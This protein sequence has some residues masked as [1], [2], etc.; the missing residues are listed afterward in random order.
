MDGWTDGYGEQTDGQVDTGNGRTEGRTLGADGRTDRRT[1]E[2]SGGQTDGGMDGRTD[3]WTDTGLDG[4]VDRRTRGTGSETPPQTGSPEFGAGSH[5][6]PPGPPGAVNSSLGLAVAAGEDAALVCGPTSRQAC[7]VNVH[8]NGF[9]VQL[10]SALRP[11]RSLPAA[12]PECP[13]PSMDIAFLMDG[14]GSIAPQDFHT[15]KNFVAQVMWR[16]RDAD[17]Q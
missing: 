10:D 13:K 3:G 17:V 9:C 1:R 16:F 14:S 12:F 7:G 6:V 8:L 4:R 15:M 5:P 2:W 11:V